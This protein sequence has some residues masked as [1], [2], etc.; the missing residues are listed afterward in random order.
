VAADEHALDP[1]LRAT[2]FDDFPALAAGLSRSVATGDEIVIY[3]AYDE[4]GFAAGVA[5]YAGDQRLVSDLL[6]Q[7]PS[8]ARTYTVR[9]VVGARPLATVAAPSMRPHGQVWLIGLQGN[10]DT[11]EG[12][13]PL[14]ATCRRAGMPAE[15]A[16]SDI[17]LLELTCR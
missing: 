1:A 10:A 6:G 3:Q 12:Y 13:G 16:Y 8:G 17:D 2:A 15:R 14:A 5:R 11:P 4:G 7:L 9:T